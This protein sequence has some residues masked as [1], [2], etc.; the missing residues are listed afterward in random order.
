MAEGLGKILGGD[1]NADSVTAGADLC[2]SACL[3][4]VL[5]YI[6]AIEAG[7]ESAEGWPTMATLTGPNGTI[8]TQRCMPSFSLLACAAQIRLL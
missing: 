3:K 1:R 6:A 8:S 4:K 5:D 2:D 7:N